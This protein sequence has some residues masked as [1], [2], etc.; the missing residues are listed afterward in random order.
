MSVRMWAFW[1]PTWRRVAT[2]GAV[3]VVVY[4]NAVPHCPLRPECC[5]PEDRPNGRGPESPDV[6]APRN[7]SAES[8]VV[9]FTDCAA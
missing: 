1:A 5:S 3:V 9:A 7:T 8:V 2:V 6:T 4:G